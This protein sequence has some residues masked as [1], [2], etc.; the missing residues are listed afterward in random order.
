MFSL[1]GLKDIGCEV[2]IP[3]TSDTLVGN[4]QQKARFIWENYGVNCF[5]D[6]TGLE[7]EALDMEPGVL[8]ARYAGPQR[9]AHDNMALLL[10]KLDGSVNR[11]ARF[12]TVICLII[13]GNENLFEGVVEGEIALEACGGE[14]F[15]YDPIFRPDGYSI[16]FAEMAIE[17]KNR[18]SH[19]GKAIHLLTD[20]L[21]KL[22]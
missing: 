1:K 7:V 10:K 9:N 13:E 21:S 22:R 3:E 5:A 20:F 8:S 16:S 12:R 11:K 17:E 4:A 2:D 14:G 6:D 15:G 18:I 19:R